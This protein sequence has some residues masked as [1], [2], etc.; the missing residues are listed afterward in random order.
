MRF[1]AFLERSLSLPRPK[2]QTPAERVR[3]GGLDTS[4]N[5]DTVEWKELTALWGSRAEVWNK[6]WQS[7]K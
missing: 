6:V 1:S 2:Q 3:A 5:V 4:E 7:A